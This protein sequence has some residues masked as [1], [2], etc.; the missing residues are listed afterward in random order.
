MTSG[1]TNQTTA[2]AVENGKK[3]PV[4]IVTAMAKSAT[5]NF[6]TRNQIIALAKAGT[7]KNV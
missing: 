3:K 4:P 5:K 6:G 2:Q 7:S 1:T